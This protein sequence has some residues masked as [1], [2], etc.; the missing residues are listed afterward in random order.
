MCAKGQGQD[1]GGRLTEGKMNLLAIGG[2]EPVREKQQIKFRGNQRVVSQ[3][4][5]TGR[6]GVLNETTG[7]L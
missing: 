7:G 1:D 4:K 3:E 2:K 5:S 6:R